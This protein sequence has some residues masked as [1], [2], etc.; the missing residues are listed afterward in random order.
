MPLNV[1]SGWQWLGVPF[2]QARS[3]LS[4][5]AACGSPGS[6]S[7]GIHITVQLRPLGA[8]TVSAHERQ[9]PLDKRLAERLAHALKF[10]QHI[11]RHGIGVRREPQG[12]QVSL[13]VRIA[14]PGNYIAAGIRP[15]REYLPSLAQQLAA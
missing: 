15:E 13:S 6:S 7:Q 3:L 10:S 5:Q 2:C 4:A 11:C 12:Q 9:H 14:P 8:A 1:A